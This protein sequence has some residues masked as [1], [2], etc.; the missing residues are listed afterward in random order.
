MADIEDIISADT[1]MKIF[2]RKLNR[3][4]DMVFSSILVDGLQVQLSAKVNAV[5]EAFSN[6]GCYCANTAMELVRLPIKIP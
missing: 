4:F 3:M 2:V 5:S 6:P 1:R